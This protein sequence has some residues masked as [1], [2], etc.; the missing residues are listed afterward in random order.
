MG[1]EQKADKSRVERI[2]F[3]IGSTCGIL[4]SF[5]TIYDRVIAPSPPKL[6][7]TFFESG[8]TDLSI[9]PPINTSSE[10]S[11]QIP[12]RLKI[13]NVGGKGS[14]NTKLYLTHNE[15]IQI[16]AEYRKEL[17]QTWTVPNQPQEQVS[18][19]IENLNPGESFIVPTKIRFRIPRESQETM[20]RPR[21][22]LQPKDLIPIG[23]T[24]GADISSDAVPNVH[25][26]LSLSLG[27]CAVLIERT[28][29]V[30]WVG[31]DQN[32]K[33]PQLLRVKEDYPCSD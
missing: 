7:V 19:T 30:F 4:T 25:G 27:R 9:V 32:Q 31:Y 22:Q 15:S 12:V 5:I 2:F 24:I 3:W 28:Q 16:D 18:L 8:T 13:E 11:D 1:D 17:K 21:D 23:F 6:K 14:A 10:F 20:R 33:N 26:T 29:N